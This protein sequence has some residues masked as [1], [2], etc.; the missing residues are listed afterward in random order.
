[1]NMNT[2]TLPKK[3]LKTRLY[4]IGMNKRDLKKLSKNQLIKLLMEREEKK[5]KNIVVDDTKPVPTPRPPVPTPRNKVNQLVQF[6]EN[7]PTPLP[8]TGKWENVKPK[9]IPRKSVLPPPKGFRDR[10][11]KPSRDPPLPP[12]PKHEFNF[13]DDIFQTENQNLEKFKIISVQS[14]AK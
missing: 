10:P 2:T 5:S 12:T 13:D 8:R 3:G 6:F 11:P 9:P 14:R 4:N 1:M 7:K